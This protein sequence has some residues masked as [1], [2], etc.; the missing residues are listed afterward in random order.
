MLH[1]PSTSILYFLINA[2]CHWV[3]RVSF[4]IRPTTDAVFVFLER[5]SNWDNSS[6]GSQIWNDGW[7]GAFGMHV[8]YPYI[9][10]MAQCGWRLRLPASS[11][12]G[13]SCMD[14]KKHKNNLSYIITIQ[15]PPT[16]CL[17]NLFS[18]KIETPTQTNPANPPPLTNQRWLS[19]LRP[20]RVYA[21]TM[22]S[23]LGRT[24]FG[25]S[26]MGKLEKKKKKK[27]IFFSWCL[28][29]FLLS[30]FS[31]SK[32]KFRSFQNCLPFIN[33]VRGGRRR[34]GWATFPK[35]P[36][37]KKGPRHIQ[38][39]IML[40]TREKKI[41]FFVG[42][43]SGSP[44]RISVCPLRVYLSIYTR[45]RAISVWFFFLLFFPPLW[46]VSV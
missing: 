19:N 28:S 1:F 30:E 39:W 12:F 44:R 6:F 16:P 22:M 27:R 11:F 38:S 31:K 15:T 33:L 14:L 9:L 40:M 35:P 21:R 18:K 42:V 32:S 20:P 41:F 43:S 46:C 3:L 10:H 13:L 37:T 23:R 5:P 2:I 17:N 8:H 25:Y 24:N 34:R 7:G 45:E 36:P 4:L 29:F 26:V